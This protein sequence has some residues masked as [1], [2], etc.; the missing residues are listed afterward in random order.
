MKNTLLMLSLSLVLGCAGGT[1]V[2]DELAAAR[3]EEQTASTGQG[4][5]ACSPA[6]YLCDSTG[7]KGGC[8]CTTSCGAKLAACTGTF[9]LYN[10]HGLSCSKR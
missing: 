8:G 10:D 2:E 1:S 7:E 5:Q 9:C 6:G 3:A 4:L